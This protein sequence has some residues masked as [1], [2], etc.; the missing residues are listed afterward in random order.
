MVIYSET[1]G[2]SLFFIFSSSKSDNGKE[3]AKIKAGQKRN[4][5]ST[6]GCSNV[7]YLLFLL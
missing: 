2:G 3:N 7:A 1:E 6:L 5:T 4:D